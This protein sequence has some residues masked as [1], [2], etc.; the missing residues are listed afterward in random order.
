LDRLKEV[1]K[2]CLALG[3]PCEI[4]S[5]DVTRRAEVESW[6]Q[7]H[8]DLLAQVQVLVNNAGLARG[9]QPIQEDSVDH[10]D[11]MIDT[12]LKGFLYLLNA[13]LPALRARG[14]GHLIFLGSVAGHWNYPKGHVYCATKHA[15][16]S[17]TESI[18][19]DLNGSGIRVTEISPGMVETEFS[20]V[21]LESDEKARAVYAGMT[22]L[23]PE[24]IADT[25]VW[26][27]SRPARVN[28]QEVVIYPTDQASPT[29]VHRR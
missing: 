14:S 21:R 2:E 6:A 4:A 26:C 16:H 12:N 11:E 5:L 7:T 27:E 29:V 22:P 24:D 18:R 8:A 1:Q 9:L 28:I 25:I 20:R 13:V 23:T 15:V 17:L 3:A 10:W 19:L